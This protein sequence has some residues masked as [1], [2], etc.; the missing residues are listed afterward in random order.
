MSLSQIF[1][2]ICPMFLL[3]KEELEKKLKEVIKKE[4]RSLVLYEYSILNYYERY[5]EKVKGIQ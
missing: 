3:Q 1:K 2:D 5:L 4:E